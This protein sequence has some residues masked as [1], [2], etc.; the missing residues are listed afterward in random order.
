MTV[1]RKPYLVK[2]S[3]QDM[4]RTSMDYQS[5]NIK[6]SEMKKPYLDDGSF[7]GMENM[8][9]ANP[10]MRPQWL[11]PPDWDMPDAPIVNDGAIRGA[12]RYVFLCSADGCYCPGETTCV[13]FSCMTTVPFKLQGVTG[14]GGL[15]GLKGKN[16]RIDDG[17]GQGQICI[18]TPS[19]SVS[20]VDFE[21]TGVAYGG[22]VEKSTVVV[23]PCEFRAYSEKCAGCVCG[24][25]SIGYTTNQMSTGGT[26]NLTVTGAVAGCTYNWAIT[27]GGGTL[28][29]STGTSITYTAPSSN[30]NCTNNPTITMSCGSTLKGTLK[31]AVNA[32]SSSAVVY[33][34]SATC[35]N[36]TSHWIC[37]DAPP[38]SVPGNI[39]VTAFNCD[40][41]SYAGYPVGCIQS[42][43]HSCNCPDCFA[44]GKVLGLVEASCTQGTPCD[45]RT[46]AQKNAGCCPSVLL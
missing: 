16:Q 23:W 32:D 46:P 37:P 14:G 2:G 4:M 42:L 10:G 11:D 22:V 41:T 38:G 25:E 40:G 9:D 29:S 30:A 35:A 21:V 44:W 39:P 28:S 26:Q 1:S 45:L 43:G 7:Q 13:N 19:D 20:S 5:R 17:A 6:H 15:S 33:L 8:S 27:S 34:Y 3:Y 36:Y 18:T 12:N 24:A 31:I